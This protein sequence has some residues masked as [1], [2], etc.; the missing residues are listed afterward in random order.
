MSNDEVLKIAMCQA[1]LASGNLKA[2]TAI[3]VQRIEKAAHFGADI[4]L[5]GELFHSFAN[6]TEDL[7]QQ[8]NS[9]P[10]ICLYSNSEEDKTLIIF[11][12]SN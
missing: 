7:I 4:A 5:F 3:M 9:I 2:S 1:C 12:V 6:R 10:G 8:K 11:G